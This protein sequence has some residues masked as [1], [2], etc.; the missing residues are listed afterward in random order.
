MQRLTALATRLMPVAMVAMTL[1]VVAQFWLAH[2]PSTTW[3]GRHRDAFAGFAQGHAWMILGFAA[4]FW[5]ATFAGYFHERQAA[6]QPAVAKRNWIMDAL[7]RLTNRKVLEQKLA[8]SP[9]SVIIDAE[10]LAAALKSKVIGQDAVC[11]DMAA[12]IRRRLALKQRGKPVGVF[13]LAG[14]PGTGKTYLAKCLATELQRKLLHFDMTQF[15]SG[16]QGATQLF[17][18]AKGYV[19]SDTYGK[20]TAALRDTPNAVVLLDEIEK[21]HPEIHKNFL[22]AWNDGF[23]TEASDGRQIATTDAIFILTTNAATDALHALS[24][25]FAHDPDEL[26][27]ASTNA[28]KEAGFAPEVLNRI[29]RFF[30]FQRLSG[31]DI[32]RVTALEIEAMIKSYGLDVVEGGIDPDILV[33]MMERQQKLGTGASSRDLV[34]AVEESIADTLIDAKRNGDQRVALIS[35]HGKIIARP[36]Q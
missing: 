8:K 35:E 19:G 31:L 24:V 22:T 33:D 2:G 4:F 30:V 7:D 26:R 28:L 5:L 29:D 10:Q 14:P 11:D 17:G 9:E 12:Q 6:H 18:A 20:L 13:M 23:V 34:R 1:V 3:L 32:A 16:G 27:R 15:S 36:E 25:T 21:A